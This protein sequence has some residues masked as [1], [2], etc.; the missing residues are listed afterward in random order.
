MMVCVFVTIMAKF[1]A[2]ELGNSYFFVIIGNGFVYTGVP[3]IFVLYYRRLKAVAPSSI[4]IRLSVGQ[5]AVP[6]P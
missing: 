5:A 2:Q 1:S 6:C 3:G 4:T